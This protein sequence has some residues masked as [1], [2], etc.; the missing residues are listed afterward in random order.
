MNYTHI[1]SDG[2]LVFSENRYSFLSIPSR[3]EGFNNTVTDLHRSASGREV[4]CLH[5]TLD[6]M[7]TDRI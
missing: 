2:Q 6:L 3:M 5:G 7:E 4:F 1:E